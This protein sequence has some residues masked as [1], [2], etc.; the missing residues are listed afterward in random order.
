MDRLSTVPLRVGE[1]RVDPVS[2]QLSKGP[3]IVKV[4]ARAMRLLLFLAQRTGEVVSI[5]ELLERVWSGVVVTPDSVYQAIASLR[6]QLGDDPKNPRYIATVPRLGYRMVADVTPYADAPPLAVNLTKP[7]ASKAIWTAAV[8]AALAL[9]GL[10]YW[11]IGF[12]PA[13]VQPTLA[14]LPFQDLTTQEMN[15]GVFADGLTEELIGALSKN[16]ALRV[17]S[18]TAVFYYRDKSLPVHEIARQLGVGYILDGSVRKSGS[19]YRVATRLIRG[20]TG[21]VMRSDS[22]DRPLGDLLQVQKEVAGEETKAVLAALAAAN[23]Q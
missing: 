23:K 6:R 16:G 18:P 21:F 13:E 17:S 3:D 15:E 19:N 9:M 4:E 8:I 14:V 20:D 12:K 5:D 2:S 11:A 10:A 22:Y 7:S 1:W